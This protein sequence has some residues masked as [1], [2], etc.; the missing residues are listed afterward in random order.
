MLASGEDASDEEEDEEVAPAM[1]SPK[2]KEMEADPEQVEPDARA[3]AVVSKLTEIATS[4]EDLA[5]D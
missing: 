2:P 4:A 5:K 3:E 1:G